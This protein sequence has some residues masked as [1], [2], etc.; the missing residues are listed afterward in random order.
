LKKFTRRW[1]PHALSDPQKATTVEASNEL[2]HMLNDLEA[3]SFDGIPI[4][5]G[6]WSHSLSELSAM[7]AKSPGDIIPRTRKEIG[8]KK[9]MSTV[10]L[11]M[12]S[13]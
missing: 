13:Y 10:S 6:S 2:L 8:M 3:D 9:A 11:P 5:D 1:V 12:G 7:F 4:G